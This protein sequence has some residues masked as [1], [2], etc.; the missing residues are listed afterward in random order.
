MVRDW[1]G[2]TGRA[3]GVDYAISFEVV[4]P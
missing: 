3:F 1:A 4:R 2:E